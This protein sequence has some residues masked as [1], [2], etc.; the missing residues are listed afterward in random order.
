[1]IIEWFGHA[2]FKLVVEEKVIYIDPYAGEDDFYSQPADVILVS[3]SHFDHCDGDKIRKVK[4]EYTLM[5]TPADLVGRFDSTKIVAGQSLIV[6]RLRISAVKAYNTNKPMHAEG[7]GVGFLVEGEGKK[8]YFA[9]DTDLIP[10]MDDIKADIALLPVGG[11]YTM[12]AEEAAEAARKV[13][14]KVAIPMHWGY[15]IVG[16][17]F[18]AEMFKELLEHDNMTVQ[19]L[20]PGQEVDF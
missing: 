9:G 8:V 14:C 13:G 3:H 5:L 4:K 19:I 1:M 2:S 18:D 12:N 20:E 17:L 10:E 16:K 11:T 6:G 7:F 15:G